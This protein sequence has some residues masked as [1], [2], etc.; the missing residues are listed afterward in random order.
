MTMKELRT[1]KTTSHYLSIK[2]FVD[3]CSRKISCFSLSYFAQ[4]SYS[5]AIALIW[6]N[7]D[8]SWPVQV[9]RSHK[10]QIQLIGL[11]TLN[12]TKFT[13]SYTAWIS[14]R[15][16]KESIATSLSSI[17]NS[18]RSSMLLHLMK[19]KCQEN[20]TTDWTASRRWFF[21][22]LSELIRLLLPF[23]IS[24][25]KRSV[26]HSLTLQPSTLV[27]AMMTLPTFHLSFSY[28]QQVLILLLISKN[29]LKRG[30]WWQELILYL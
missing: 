10:N 27:H 4:R 19:K 24:S 18:R 6:Q 5:E 11:M 22:N 2:T 21:W 26:N 12:G 15:H 3:L 20:G 7:G 25:L 16:S 9:V 30:I 13:N 28:Y 29:M 1:W 23:R 8:S 14:L 17:R